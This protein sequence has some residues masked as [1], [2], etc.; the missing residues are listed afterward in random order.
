LAPSVIIGIAGL[1]LTSL[2][3]YLGTRDGDGD[4]SSVVAYQGQVQAAC[5]TI[6]TVANLDRAMGVDSRGLLDKGRILTAATEN[7]DATKLQFDLV[8]RLDPPKQLSE[9]K[10]KFDVAK[11]Q[12]IAFG[13]DLIN[14]L[15]RSLPARPTTAQYEAVVAGNQNTI[16]PASVEIN[17]AMS[18]LAGAECR[19]A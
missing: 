2:G 17:S 13:R 10:A 16:L 12:Y 5:R 9:A 19:V 3:L 15:D 1:V 4:R 18:G 11:D 14:R 7:L 8:S 6:L